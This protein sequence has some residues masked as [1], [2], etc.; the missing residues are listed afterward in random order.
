MWI[1]LATFRALFA[2]ACSL[3]CFVAQ[4]I[5]M[6]EQIT[7]H[8]AKMRCH[9]FVEVLLH[10]FRRCQ[11]LLSQVY[12]DF[13]FVLT[14]TQHICAASVVLRRLFLTRFRG[15]LRIAGVF[16]EVSS[17]AGHCLGERR[18]GCLVFWNGTAAAQLR[19]S[20]RPGCPCKGSKQQTARWGSVIA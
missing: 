12:N 17:S 9:V 3:S 16:H 18:S 20:L 11:L 14:N 1:A 19:T 10:L 15:F 8:P 6:N 5:F 7:A 4:A 2:R 13:E